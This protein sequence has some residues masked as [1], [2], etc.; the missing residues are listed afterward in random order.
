M[1]KIEQFVN[2]AGVCVPRAEDGRF[3]D[4]TGGS[5]EEAGVLTSPYGPLHFFLGGE[6]FRLVLDFA[7]LPDGSFQLSLDGHVDIIGLMPVTRRFERDVVLTEAWR[8]T[9]QLIEELAAEG[10]EHDFECYQADAWFWFRALCR[11]CG[12]APYSLMED[13]QLR[14]E[15]SL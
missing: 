10:I 3:L 12:K 9:E 2:I 11:E 14:W 5:E 1:P 8:L 7:E 15:D 4:W 13:H 6:D